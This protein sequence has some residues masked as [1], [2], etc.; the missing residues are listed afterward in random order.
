MSTN[1]RVVV[2]LNTSRFNEQYYVGISKMKALARSYIWWSHIE[3]VAKSCESCLL[4]ANS[5]APAPSHPWIVPKQ[6]WERVH[7]DHAF[8]GNKVLLV[9][10]DVFSKWPEVHIVSS[11]SAKQTILKATIN[12]RKSWATNHLGFRQWFTFSIRRV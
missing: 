11:T 2:P 3:A 10:I 5:P 4:T 9:A 6:P 7:L 1:A 8:W 12:L